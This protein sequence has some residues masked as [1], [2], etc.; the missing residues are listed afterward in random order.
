MNLQTAVQYLKGVGEKRA[1]T[2]RR[3]G[4]A[5]LGDLI[6]HVPRAYEDWQTITPIMLTPAG[7]LCCVRA[8]VDHA[9][10][11]HMI[12]AGLKLYK[13]RVTDGNG[14]L[15]ITIFNSGYQA[16]KLKAGEEYLFYGRISESLTAREMSSPQF[17]PTDE[18]RLRPVYPLTEGLS[19]RQLETLVVRAFEQ[20]G[21]Q[22]KEFLPEALLAQH[23]LLPRL[24]ALKAIHQPDNLEQ[25]E[26]ARRRLAFN[27]LFLL[28]LGLRLLKLG[29]D[30]H[31]AIPLPP[32]AASEFLTQLPFTPT[33]AQARAVAEAAQAMASPQP[34]YRL[35]QGDVGSGKTAVAAAL[36]YQAAQNGCQAAMLAPTE[37]LARQHHETLQKLGLDA[38][39]L[40][41]ATPAAQKKQTKLALAGGAQQIVVGTHALLQ[42]DIAFDKL[43]LVVV[44]E[45]HR[46]GVAQRDKLQAHHP[47]MLVMSATPIPRSLAM[48][49]YGDLDVSVLDE[50]PPGRTPV[51]T[52]CVDSGK[53]ARA[54]NYVKKH[55]DAGQQ[56]YIVCSRVEESESSELAA[57]KQ[58]YEKL[59]REDFAGYKL[60]L[61]HG[62]LSA[63]QKEQVMRDFASGSLQLLVA[64]TVVEVGV[65]VPNAVIMVV[66]NAER[67]GLSQLH[68]LRGRVGRGAQKSTCILIS[69][70]QNEQA[71]SRFAIMKDTNDGFEIAQRDLQL[72]GPG[73]FFGARQHGLPPFKIA[74]IAADNELL[75][76]TRAAADALLAQDPALELPEHQAL[77]KA[78]EKLFS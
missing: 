2:L 38:A 22:V 16:E 21:P 55:L 67:F 47:H 27:E 17:A 69:D 41:G 34:M 74:D 49:L 77:K 1:A 63:K 71:Q 48:I 76:Q 56:G 11:E 73:E 68:Q 6:A 66:E 50:L 59:A 29:R 53:R 61:L 78:C 3:L 25:A 37:L 32:Q 57:A 43:A 62:K 7:E 39:L 42:D 23:E 72:R 18:A 75:T 31:Q 65:D 20:I 13:T 24:D 14:V 15:N 58:F 35:L 26:Q 9:P 19:S 64:T 28:Q 70:A 60:G 54:Y 40:V 36:L 46:F 12:R 5:T 51:E 52:Y 45:Q 10:K 30:D 44:D 8:I 4:I 33:G